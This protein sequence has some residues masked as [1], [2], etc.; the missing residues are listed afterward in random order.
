MLPSDKVFN[1][2]ICAAQPRNQELQGCFK[3]A[4]R[5]NVILGEFVF[6]R[7]P[8]TYQSRASVLILRAHQDGLLKAS[9]ETKIKLPAKLLA[10][11]QH[12]DFLKQL[13]EAHEY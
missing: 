5:P 11:V 6:E 8:I 4:P 9:Y 3:P 7:C 10:A 1:C 12:F 13:R 2:R